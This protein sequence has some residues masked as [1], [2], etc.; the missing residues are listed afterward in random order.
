MADFFD[1]ENDGGKGYEP[2]KKKSS[3]WWDDYNYDRRDYSYSKGSGSRSWMSKIGGYGDDWWKPKKNPN[4]VFQELLDQLQNSANLIGDDS[5]K[6][7]VHWSNGQDTNGPGKDASG[8]QNI[9]LSPDNLLSTKSGGS[10]EISE[11]VLD[12]MTGKVYL[13]STLRETV[14][15]QAYNHAK[16]ARSVIK[17]KE[18]KLT[19]MHHCPCNS[20]KRFG[21][22]CA[23][24]P[25]KIDAGIAKDA[26]KIWEA[27]ETS[28]AR[29]KIVEDWNGFGPYIAGD[30][31][32]S[33]ATKQE[34]QDYIDQSAEI[35][36]STEAA[37]LAIAWNLLNSTDPISIPDCYDECIEAASEMMENE[38]APE[39]RFVSCVELS[40]R[41]SKIIK[42]KKKDGGSDGDG[43]GN[44]EDDGEEGEGGASAGGEGG[45]GKGG[46]SPDVCDSSLLGEVVENN[47]DIGLSEQEGSDG[48]DGSPKGSISAP[49][50]DG[51]TRLGERY[52]IVKFPIR[53][54]F[55][56]EYRKI[57]MDHSS[58]IR[59]IRSS[60]A[61][62]NN[63]SKMVSYGHRSGDIDDNSL[64]KI[65]MDDDRVMTKTDSVNSKKIAIC[66]LVDESGSMGCDSRVEDARNTAIILGESL[67]GME[68][69]SVSIYGHSAEESCEHPAVTIREYYSP[70]QNKMAACMEMD[71]R[72]QNHDSYA[73]LHTANIFNRDYG[74][75]DRKIMFVISDGEPA[76]G[77]YGGRPA[78]KHMLDISKSCE[79]RGI[80]V[81]GVGID[82]AYSTAAGKAMYGDNRFVVLKDVKSSLG[83]MSRFIRQIAMK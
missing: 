71:A 45:A 50:P 36:P 81:Y 68:G 47:T 17:A 69:I 26:I 40:D 39:D 76:G 72:C 75:Y 56:S 35:E 15:E 79:K 27:I 18:Q 7:N 6:I 3:W 51:I 2:E 4:E 16:A 31:E 25:E 57:V 78:M 55:E 33:S 48:S 64:F 32:R 28:V 1:P 70:R 13:A 66:L 43:D 60:L 30:A 11:E 22:C 83:I 42:S 80:E 63:I 34:V 8:D 53:S 74:D 61:F 62:R 65:R 12:A 44:G 77:G 14:S 58:E 21:E 5:R 9:F 41:I 29:S 52:D 38:I 37:S 73:I 20:G 82:N 24:T 59:A 19:R 49:P 10:S 23:A 54:D 46:S 67:R